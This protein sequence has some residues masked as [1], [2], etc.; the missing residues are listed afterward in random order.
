MSGTICKVILIGNVGRD[1]EV[2]DIGHSGK[3]ANL[4]VATSESWKDKK[5]G[6]RKEK[7]EWHR[8]AI[9]GQPAEH[10][11]KYVSKGDKIYIE[12]TLQT[13]KWEDKNGQEK[14]TTEIVVQ[15]F[16]SK[17]TFLSPPKGGGQS[18]S[19]SENFS[20]EQPSSKPRDDWRDSGP[21]LEDQI[22]F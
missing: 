11:E 7:T 17:V 15:G 1:P 9:F 18:R 12:G 6:E 8:V 4:A 22:P 20:R 21:P 2:R 13:R 3:V 10:V 5:T 16:N 14:Y 19:S